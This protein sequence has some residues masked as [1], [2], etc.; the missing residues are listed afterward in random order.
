MSGVPPQQG[1]EP[2]RAPAGE[3]AFGE[4]ITQ[5]AEA[6]E[7]LMHLFLKTRQHMIDKARNDVDWSTFLLMTAVVT[8]GPLRVKELAEQVQ[9]DPSTVSRHVAQLVRDGFLE[10]HADAVDGRASLLT[11]TDKAREAVDARKQRRNLHYEHMLH[12]WEDSE[13]GQLTALVARFADD[14]LAYKT[15]LADNDGGPFRPAAR[16]ETTQ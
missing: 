13:R 15:K 10:R 7:R 8:Q 11:A 16:K 9:S 4:P 14:F 6:M 1:P 5:L 2:A 3:C 12:T